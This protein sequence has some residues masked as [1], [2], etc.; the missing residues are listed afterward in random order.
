MNYEIMSPEDIGLT[1]SP[2]ILSS[3]SGRHA[4]KHRLHQLGYTIEAEVFNR[5]YDRF[6]ELA[7]KKKQVTDADL[8]SLIESCTET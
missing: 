4:F 5:A 2:L 7:D 3:R 6:L 8:V 1:A